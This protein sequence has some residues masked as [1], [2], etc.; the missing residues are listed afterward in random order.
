MPESAP[1]ELTEK[2]I[3][4]VLKRELGT[5]MVLSTNPNIAPELKTGIMNSLTAFNVLSERIDNGESLPTAWSEISFDPQTNF[6][7]IRKKEG[8]LYRTEKTYVS[9]DTFIKALKNYHGHSDLVSIEEKQ[10]LEEENIH[11]E[12]YKKK[13]EEDARNGALWR[14]RMPGGDVAEPTETPQATQPDIRPTRPVRSEGTSTPRP[15]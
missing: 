8:K 15:R 4:K 2:A 7:F 3:F 6:T 9:P 10:S 13:L 14:G 12:E 11:L 1:A 5:Y